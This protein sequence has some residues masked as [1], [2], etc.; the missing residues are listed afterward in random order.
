MLILFGDYIGVLK[1]KL[2]PIKKKKEFRFI[3]LGGESL[4]VQSHISK[5]ISCTL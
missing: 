4:N 5:N 1:M 3:L 2:K